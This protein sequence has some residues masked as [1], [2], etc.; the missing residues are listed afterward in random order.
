MGVFYDYDY[1]H[2]GAGEE[3]FSAAE[4]EIRCLFWGEAVYLLFSV[5]PFS[6]FKGFLGCILG[7]VFSG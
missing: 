5:I 6:M 7:S 3:R 4:F 2:D 1:G